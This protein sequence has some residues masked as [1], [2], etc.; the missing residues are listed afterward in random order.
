M[1]RRTTYKDV[2]IKCFNCEEIFTASLPE[3]GVYP[4]KR[5]CDK[6]GKTNSII[7]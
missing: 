7:W 1:P 2:K 6:C 4:Q 3:T 5:K